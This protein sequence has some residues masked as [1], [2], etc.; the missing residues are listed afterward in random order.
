[1]ARHDLATVR[2][3]LRLARDAREIPPDT[4]RI[5]LQALTEVDDRLARYETEGDG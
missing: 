4:A 1:M 3:R 2:W 5:L